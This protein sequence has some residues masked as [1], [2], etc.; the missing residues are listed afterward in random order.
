[1]LRQPCGLSFDIITMQFAEIGLPIGFCFTWSNKAPFRQ[2]YAGT[3]ER[4]TV[5][6]KIRVGIMK[7]ITVRYRADEDVGLDMHE[8][9]MRHPLDALGALD[10]TDNVSWCLVRRQFELAG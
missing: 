2:K 5:G 3:N 1:M 8:D 4:D 7:A 10:A 6:H 9:C